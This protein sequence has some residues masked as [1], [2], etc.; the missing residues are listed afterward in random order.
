MG[1]LIGLFTG[2]LGG[3]LVGAVGA[4]FSKWFEARNEIKKEELSIERDKLNNQHE[5]EVMKTETD[6]A[7]KMKEYEA[8]STSLKSDKASYSVGRDSKW[9]TFVDVVRG[10][11]RPSITALLLIYCAA[12]LVYL[13]THYQVEFDDTQVYELVYMIVHNLVTCSGIALTW[14]F[15]SRATS[16]NKG[17]K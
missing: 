12:M 5:L 15:G 6:S 16:I 7:V 10:L 3:S 14:W 2:S 8:L 9:L 13:T 4:G 11:V 17:Q 1:D